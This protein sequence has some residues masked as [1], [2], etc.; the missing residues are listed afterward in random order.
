MS[1]GDTTVVRIERARRAQAQW[2]K[3]SADRR[4]NA[5]RSLRNEIA[6]QI[7]RIVAVISDEVGKP[8][9]DVLTGD[10]MVTL[11]HLRYYERNA[12]R[13]LRSRTVGKPWFFFTGT[14][15]SESRQPYGVALIF[16]PWNYP[17]QLAVVPMITALFAGNAA[18]LK[19]S[20]K[21]PRTAALIASLC[22]NANLPDDLVQVSCEPPEVAAALISAG[23]DF[24]FFTG[25]SRNGRVV[26]Q[27]AAARLARDGSAVAEGALSRE[28]A[29]AR[30]CR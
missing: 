8:P 13:F 24:L 15:F 14:R 9:L 27:L 26:A 17:F 18:L 23:P 12:D 4:G 28:R 19:C 2:A 30:D 1:G 25:S 21:T 11:E 29:R 6:S 5:L 7:D 20:E 3:L 10:I 22:S 16:A